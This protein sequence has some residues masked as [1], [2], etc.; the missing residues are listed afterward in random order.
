MRSELNLNVNKL[1]R[2]FR[3]FCDS[4]LTI[5]NLSGHLVRTNNQHRKRIDC[6]N[7]YLPF[8]KVWAPLRRIWRIQTWLWLGPIEVE[9]KIEMRNENDSKVHFYMRKHASKWRCCCFQFFLSFCFPRQ[10]P[11]PQ[12]ETWRERFWDS[13][14]YCSAQ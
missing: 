4:L 13:K 2:S 7:T 11:N 1:W 12:N 5:K 14:T 3:L 9:A 10:I 6:R 8:L